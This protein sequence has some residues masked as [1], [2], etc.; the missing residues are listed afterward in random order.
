M[1]TLTDPRP[2]VVLLHAS[3]SSSRQ[4]ST[5]AAALA[6][7]WRVEA[8]DFHGHGAR[9][10]HDGG[11]AP[12][13]D[14]D[15]A[16]VAPLLG[17]GAHLVGHS[18]GGAIALKLAH[19]RPDRV[20]SVFAYEP[21]LFGLLRHEP[22]A[23]RDTAAVAAAMRERLAAGDAAAAGRRFIDH[24][25]GD[26][27]WDAMPPARQAAAAARMATIARQFDALYAEPLS[28][29]DL[30]RLPMP[31]RLASGGRTLPVARA[32]VATLLAALPR[33]GHEVLPRL[34]HLG[35]I[36]DA[37]AFDRRV[38]AFLNAQADALRPL[39]SP[40]RERLVTP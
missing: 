12:S 27:S 22:Q 1:H 33:S 21:V 2:A 36:T 28:A 6:P 39:R 10:A 16:L 3:A 19:E 14:A 23:L 17:R 7:H 11:D 40:D 5:L 37:A 13:L 26:G 38:L 24:W 8:I 9:P 30:A 31:V 15:A 29:A 20:R 34:G 32:I 4:W 18:Y 35:P 25:S